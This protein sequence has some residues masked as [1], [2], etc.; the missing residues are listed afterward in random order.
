M[1]FHRRLRDERARAAVHG[2]RA[3]D[4][5]L[6]RGRAIARRVLRLRAVTRSNG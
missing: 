3:V 1:R 5:R 2:H 4:D 6:G